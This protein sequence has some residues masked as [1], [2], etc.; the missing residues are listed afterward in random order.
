MK[1][2]EAKLADKYVAEQERRLS[3]SRAA[4]PET[5]SGDIVP[6]SEGLDADEVERLI[7]ELDG[8][9]SDIAKAMHVRSD[10]VRAFIAVKPTLKRAMAEVFEGEVDRAVAVLQAALRDEHSFQNRFY[11][12]KEWLKSDL[13]RKRGFGREQ[14]LAATLEVKGGDGGRTITLKWIEPDAP[15]APKIIEGEAS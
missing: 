15:E 11:G 9:V 10:R 6:F 1:S 12:A 8:N 2:R 5:A 3:E 14:G 13:G 4:E 7:F